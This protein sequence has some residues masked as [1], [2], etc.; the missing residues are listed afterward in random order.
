MNFSNMTGTYEFVHAR[1]LSVA[2][3]REIVLDA[4]VSQRSIG[5]GVSASVVLFGFYPDPD[6]GGD[7]VGA[8][9]IDLPIAV[10]PDSVP[11]VVSFGKLN[12]IPRWIRVVTRMTQ[13]A[14]PEDLLLTMSLQLVVRE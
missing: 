7:V 11:G 8:D 9:L 10:K 5:A 4:R 3:A 1:A 14:T 6:D 12:N 13:P 2:G